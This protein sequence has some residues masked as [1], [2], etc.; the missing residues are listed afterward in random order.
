MKEFIN[1][2]VMYEM[3]VDLYNEALSPSERCDYV[4]IIESYAEHTAN[5]IVRDMRKYV[6]QD[7]T[8]IFGNFANIREDWDYIPDFVKSKV[9]PFGKFD[10]MVK[11][12]DDGTISDEDLAKV[13]EWCFAWFFTAFGTY[14]L[15]YN[16]LT[17]LS[18]IEMC[19]DD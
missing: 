12:V 10:D 14:N 19:S 7:D 9:K 13:Q 15:K 17:M 4:D 18:D 16:F 11:S 1:F 6:H 2:D 8:K 5:G 3:L